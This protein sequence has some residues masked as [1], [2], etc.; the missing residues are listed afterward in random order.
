MTKKVLVPIADGVEEIESMT[1]IDMLRRAGA[2]L[3][4]A[5]VQE[6]RVTAAHGVVIVA[7][8]LIRDCIEEE[9]DLVA[10]PG[11]IPGATNL[12]NS[13]DLIRILKKQNEKGKRYA[14]I[15]ASPAVV[16]KPHGLLDAKRAT[17]YPGFSG[18]LGD[19]YT[20]SAA[21]VTDG[22]CTTSQGVGTA[23]EFAL[24]LVESLYGSEKAE[25][26]SAAI[27]FR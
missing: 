1:V 22:N 21:V 3:T 23:I 5:S 9:Y 24:Q 8:R 11:G 4:V 18:D 15:C 16:L 10:L 26:L 27:L 19:S 17:C 7:D 14:A 12:A 2:D 25:E 13:D 20:D 6:K